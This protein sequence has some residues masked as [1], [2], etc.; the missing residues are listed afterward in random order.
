MLGPIVEGERIRL[1]PPN[2]EMLATFIQ[3]LADP[4]VT[5]YMG[6]IFPPG[7]AEEKEWFAQTA[8]SG[9][10]LIWA[11]YAI[12]RPEPRLIGTTGLHGINWSG[13]RAIT[14]NLIGEKSEWGKGYG[15]EV[16]QLRT[17]Y[18]FT[19]LPLEQLRT[20][21]AMPNTASR[22]ALEKAGY[23]QYGIAPKEFF[24]QGAWHDAWLA[25][26]QREDWE[27]DR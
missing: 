1:A 12:D 4:E 19:N 14:G 25:A 8:K 16:V 10:H 11:V 20:E 21:V 7:M 15:S 3:W 13:R 17:D 6:R 22:R 18:A 23:K 24:R 5:R 9:D 27:R 2:E 26:I